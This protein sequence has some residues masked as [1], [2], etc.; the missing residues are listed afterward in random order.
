LALVY[1]K[2]EKMYTGGTSTYSRQL[3][4]S[5]NKRKIVY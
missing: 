5:F 3:T 2:C 4:E 1:I